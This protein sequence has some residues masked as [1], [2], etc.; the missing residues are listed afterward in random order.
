[1]A[2]AGDGGIHGGNGAAHLPVVEDFPVSL[3]Q[4]QAALVFEFVLAFVARTQFVHGADLKRRKSA[5]TIFL[6]D[7]M[8][9]RGIS[10]SLGKNQHFI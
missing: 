6:R 5:E 9:A 10:S 1:M 2:V 8:R 3:A 4:H 7:E